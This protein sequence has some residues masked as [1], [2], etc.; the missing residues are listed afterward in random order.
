M[1]RF[2]AGGESLNVEHGK[3]DQDSK[4]RSL[5]HNT[6]N[7]LQ[8]RNLEV[9]T[10]PCAVIISPNLKKLEELKRGNTEN[11]FNTI[12]DDNQY[13]LAGSIQYLDSLK[14]KIIHINSEGSLV[15][16]IPH[17]TIFKF[18]ADSVYW[19][20]LLFNGRTKPLNADITNINQD[21]ESYMRK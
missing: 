6:S 20:V 16:R 14:V 11:D 19:G 15:F 5:V 9:I 17:G 4:L 3:H 8:H 18:R 1:D 10:S 7:N 13:Y 21:Y 2:F 12:V